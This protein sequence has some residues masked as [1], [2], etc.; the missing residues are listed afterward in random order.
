LVYD[1]STAEILK[2]PEQF[3]ATLNKILG[4]KHPKKQS[5]QLWTDSRMKCY[6]SIERP[7]I[8]WQGSLNSHA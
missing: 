3:E 4:K 6:L 2:Q 8:C 7:R 1:L 5:N